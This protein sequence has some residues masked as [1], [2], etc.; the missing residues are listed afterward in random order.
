MQVASAHRSV[1][2]LVPIFAESG[3]HHIPVID[4]D[5][6][7]AGMITQSDLILALYNQRLRETLNA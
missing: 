3:H 7:L 5:L 1:V 6:R 2:E 4:D